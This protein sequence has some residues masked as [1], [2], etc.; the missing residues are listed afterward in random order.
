[1]SE[2][3]I[4]QS[5]FNALVKENANL[6]AENKSLTDANEELKK[7]NTEMWEN[8]VKAKDE[9]KEKHKKQMLELSTE[10]TALETKVKTFTEK[11]GI[12]EDVTDL[13]SHLDGIS[14]DLA[15]YSSIKEE[16][17]KE[18]AKN[19][20]K[21]TDFIK[22]LDK[23]WEDFLQEQADIFWESVLKNEKALK[24]FAEAKGFKVEWAENSDKP[25]K[26]WKLEAWETPDNHDSFDDAYNSWDSQGMMWEILKNLH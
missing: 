4:S 25:I 2:Q 8:I 14:Q 18:S 12:W 5:E 3:V 19:I 21:Y 1:M 15:S 20:E 7:T 17:E 23:E 11:L 6:K 22:N 24:G 16:Q 10:K 13:G 9:L 26:V